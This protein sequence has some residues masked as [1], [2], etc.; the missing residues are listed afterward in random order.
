[1]GT[2]FNSIDLSICFI[3]KIEKTSGHSAVIR[4]NTIIIMIIMP[5]SNLGKVSTNK[6]N[7]IVNQQNLFC[8]K[9]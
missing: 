6:T 7:T 5:G 8:C 1:M 3:K 2:H 4:V 9:R